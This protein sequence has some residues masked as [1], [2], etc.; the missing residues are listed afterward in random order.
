MNIGARD[1]KI[2]MMIWQFFL[3]IGNKLPLALKKFLVHI[4]Y[5]VKMLKKQTT[6]AWV[7]CF[8]VLF[9]LISILLFTLKKLL[10]AYEHRDSTGFSF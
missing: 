1:H 2:Q 4:I 8:K 6:K 3:E 7:R 10:K 5:P 9:T